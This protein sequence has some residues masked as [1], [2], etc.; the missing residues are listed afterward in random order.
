[1]RDGKDGKQ[2]RSDEMERKGTEHEVGEFRLLDKLC[3]S[4]FS[5]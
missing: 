3:L 5:A 1:M 2:A 4:L